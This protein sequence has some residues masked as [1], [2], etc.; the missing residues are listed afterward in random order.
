LQ[1]ISLLPNIKKELLNPK[2]A[3]EVLKEKKNNYYFIT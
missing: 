3:K 2:K 1:K